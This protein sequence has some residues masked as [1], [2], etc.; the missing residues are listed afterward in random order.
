[1]SYKIQTSASSFYLVLRLT[2]SVLS[3]MKDNLEAY[4][5]EKKNDSY[6]I[7]I[8]PSLLVFA[9]GG[10]EYFIPNNLCQILLKSTKSLPLK[11]GFVPCLFGDRRTHD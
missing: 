11:T 1:M 8:I 6:V 2:G 9:G 3:I 10:N 4:S 7:L 5:V